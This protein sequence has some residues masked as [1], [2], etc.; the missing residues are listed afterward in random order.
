MAG[1]VSGLHVFGADVGPEALSLLDGNYGAL[2]LALNTLANFTNYYV[3]S[4]GANAIVVTTV[5]AQVFTYVDGVVLEI[6]VAATNTSTTPTLNVNGLGAKQIVNT[7]G[8]AL[9]AGA[10]LGGG[11]YRFIFN[12]DVNSFVLQNPTVT[13]GETI[14]R[15]K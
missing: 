1:N 7:D 5:G 9:L 12:T 2:V 13:R 8:S 10:M 4:G 14:C 6:K 15:V 11:R 3:D